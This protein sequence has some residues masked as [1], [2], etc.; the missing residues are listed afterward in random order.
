MRHQLISRYTVFLQIVRHCF[1]APLR[2]LEIVLGTTNCVAIPIHVDGH[3]WIVLERRRG[4]VQRR[5]VVRTDVVFVEVEVD[6]TQDDMG[7][8][9]QWR[10]SGWRW[11]RLAD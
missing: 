5:C 6:T 9:R 8:W 3:A 1:G 2:E 4:F 11:W 10:R 7:R